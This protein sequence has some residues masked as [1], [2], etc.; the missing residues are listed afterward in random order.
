MLED[1][2][3]RLWVDKDPNN[4][5]LFIGYALLGVVNLIAI[6]LYTW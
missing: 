6:A 4:K 2:Y 1:I 5:K 3:V